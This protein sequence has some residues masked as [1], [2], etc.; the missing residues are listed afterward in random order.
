MHALKW[1]MNKYFVPYC[2]RTSRNHGN[3]WLKGGGCS[4]SLSQ[5]SII[6]LWRHARISLQHDW[7]VVAAKGV[8]VW[9]QTTSIILNAL[10]LAGNDGAGTDRWSQGTESLFKHVKICFRTYF[11]FACASLTFHTTAYL[12]LSTPQFYQ[13]LTGTIF[14]EVMWP[15]GSALAWQVCG[16][17]LTPTLVKVVFNKT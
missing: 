13:V 5:L 17:G 2:R 7:Q 11:P 14:I 8:G 15:S 9:W 1:R 4:T 10:K 6:S 3:G 16:C 12:S